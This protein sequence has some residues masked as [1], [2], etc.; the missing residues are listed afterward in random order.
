MKAKNLVE[1]AFMAAVMCV[2]AMISIP[3]G[4]IHITL[5]VLAVLLTAVLLGWKKG[6]IATAVFVG[7]G[8][9]GIPVFGGMGLGGGIA[10]LAGP[11]GGYIYSYIPMAFITGAAAD[12]LWSHQKGWIRVAGTFLA[13]LVSVAVCYTLGTIQF[14][15]VMDTGLGAALAACVIP[16]IPFDIAKSVVATG[17]GL[18]LRKMIKGL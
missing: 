14:M 2:C 1:C 8:L 15:A 4:M 10:M 9:A 12:W 16:F 6:T 17:L 7:I 3:V 13:C 11:T 5:S 18:K